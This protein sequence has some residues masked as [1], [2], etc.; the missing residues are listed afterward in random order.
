MVDKPVSL[1][2]VRLEELRGQALA[3]VLNLNELERHAV[4]AAA[5]SGADSGV[6]PS[7]QVS[8]L[9]G[10]VLVNASGARQLLKHVTSAAASTGSDA[11]VSSALQLQ[12]LG[13]QALVSFV[14][15]SDQ[16]FQKH[17][18]S[19]SALT[20]AEGGHQGSLQLEKLGAE[21]L[22]GQES[23]VSAPKTPISGG[24]SLFLKNWAVAF[25]LLTSWQ[26]TSRR[27]PTAGKIE[28]V[29]LQSKPQRELS[30]AWT[31]CDDD[32]LNELEQAL[33]DM[34]GSKQLLPIYA[35]VSELKPSGDG[36]A[37]LW[38]EDDVLFSSVTALL[39]DAATSEQVTIDTTNRRF[40]ANGAVALF[41]IDAEGKLDA[42]EDVLYYNIL[43]VQASGL[44]LDAD[45]F[46]SLSFTNKRWFAVPV[47][48]CEIVTEPRKE[49]LR[50]D[51]VS[52]FIDAIEVLSKS[53]LAP[54]SLP[55][56]AS[57]PELLLA[58]DASSQITGS[59]R[60][61]SLLVQSGR[62]I[63][64]EG[65][66]ERYEYV[67]SWPM[68]LTRAEWQ[69][70]TELFDGRRG[71]WL[72]FVFPDHSATFDSF[73]ISNSTSLFLKP[74]TSY[75]KFQQRLAHSGY[76]AVLFND[77]SFVIRQVSTI[78]DQ[79]V[80]WLVV[81]TEAFDNSTYSEADVVSVFPARLGFFDNDTLEETW[82]APDTVQVSFSTVENV[83]PG[84]V[85]LL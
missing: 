83:D 66:G 55:D 2:P 11:S 84:G 16:R 72:P 42:T 32:E 49:F 68:T 9:K 40:R 35:D 31:V 41:A 28:R 14:A 63:V 60:R 64:L 19:A 46:P 79:S 3:R 43:S 44:T 5:P 27:S 7:L 53:S 73:G 74:G 80:S 78:S 38:S 82:V 50:K 52:V 45:S 6:T 70:L 4:A 8:E 67:Q 26:T 39:S 17:N 59:L 20:G 36:T 69:S 18:V 62:S 34:T 13:A 61:P 1:T 77:G 58:P 51:G 12:E 37:L 54:A 33:R 65:Q 48:L 81:V 15:L 29:S 10:Q 23:A 24:G 76:V 85:D 47:L 71:R 57:T 56:T 21:F 30:F 25:R 75:A 22:L